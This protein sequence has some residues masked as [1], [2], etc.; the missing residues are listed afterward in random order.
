MDDTI[1]PV[2]ERVVVQAFL[3]C[4]AITPHGEAFDLL[5]ITGDAEIWIDVAEDG[6]VSWGEGRP[7]WDGVGP[8]TCE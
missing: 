4:E 1:R 2:N 8:L 6:S 7:A 3:V 5:G